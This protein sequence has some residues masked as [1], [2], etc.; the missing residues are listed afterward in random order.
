MT[1]LVVEWA[2]SWLW[3]GCMLTLV[4]AGI[5]RVTTRASATTR[6]LAWWATL[7]AVLLL[8]VTPFAGTPG[9]LVP[10]GNLSELPDLVDGNPTTPLL[11]LT[12]PTIPTW[13]G[14]TLAVAWCGFVVVRSCTLAL[15]LRRLRSVKRATSALPY[16]IEQ[17]LPLWLHVRAQGRP[18]ELRLSTRVTTASMLGLGSPIIAL[19]PQLV[20]SIS[21]ADLD[22]VVLHEYGHVQRL[23]D[24]SMIAQ[25]LIDAVF[26]WHPAIWWIGR[27]LHLERE[28]SSDDWVARHTSAPREYAACLTRIGELALI[29]RDLPHA[30]RAVRSRR[31]LSDRVERLLTPARNVTG[32][33]AGITLTAGALTLSGA[34]WLLGLAPPLISS[35]AERL[36]GPVP[37]APLVAAEPVWVRQEGRRVTIPGV[38]AR[39]VPA[40]RAFRVEQNH[41]ADLKIPTI[42]L[43]LGAVTRPPQI[44]TRLTSPLQSDPLRIDGRVSAPRAATRKSGLRAG[45]N[46]SNDARHGPWT[47][48]AGFGKT[49][50]ASAAEAGQVTASAFQGIGSTFARVFS[51]G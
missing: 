36:Q 34:V 37:S 42:P 46:G 23:D 17:H 18:A 48:V 14:V 22:R 12:V 6:F 3:Q 7:A 25:A 10:A 41:T 20:D 16:D 9:A 24:W 5:L 40:E 11:P 47:R 8:G 39:S 44:A 26:G 21:R 51:G 33:P 35:A 13:F 32:R 30:A 49:L 31:E 38:S 28:V 4:V 50:G 19:P 27:Q 45:P 2:L 29:Q 15:S 43:A 1:T